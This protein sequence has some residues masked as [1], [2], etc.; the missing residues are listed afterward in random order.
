MLWMKD[1][2]RQVVSTF[3]NA[4]FKPSLK[5]GVYAFHHL[6]ISCCHFLPDCLLQIG[7]GARF[8][9]ID[10]WFEVSPQKKSH[11]WSN[12]ET[13]GAMGCLRNVKWPF[14][15]TCD[16]PRPL[17]IVQCVGWHHPVENKHFACCVDVFSFVDARKC[18]ACECNVQ[19]WLSQWYHFKNVLFPSVTLY[20]K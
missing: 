18:S 17:T 3:L 7:Q 5:I 19:R 6:T 9:S 13:L 10:M 16:E 12:Q 8:V 11:K 14:L 15:E 2:V 4:V 1:N 20:I